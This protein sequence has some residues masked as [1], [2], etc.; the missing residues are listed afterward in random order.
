MNP[1]PPPPARLS[2]EE[3]VRALEVR[4]V[5]EAKQSDEFGRFVERSVEEI[6]SAVADERAQHAAMVTCQPKLA[7]LAQLR[8]ILVEGIVK[9]QFAFA[10]DVHTTSLAVKFLDRFLGADRFAVQAS[11]GWI[12]HLVA[13]ACQ[14]I[15]VKFL[16]RERAATARGV[17]RLF[18]PPRD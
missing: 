18:P 1:C 16:V 14:T 10:L 8:G 3:T 17:D 2:A 6:R 15:A 9:N 7:E 12:Y 5:R 4:V 11:Q 13:N